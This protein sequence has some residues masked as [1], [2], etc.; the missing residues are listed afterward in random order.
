MSSFE[1]PGFNRG[2]GCRPPLACSIIL[3]GRC[4]ETTQAAKAATTVT[5]TKA[6]TI[7]R[8][9]STRQIMPL[10]SN[11]Y[12]DDV[13]TQASASTGGPA[14]NLPPGLEDKANQ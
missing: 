6:T 14:S 8:V 13:A 11:S 12:D 2:F 5:T 10:C 9:L 1:C 4:Q 3:R 7:T